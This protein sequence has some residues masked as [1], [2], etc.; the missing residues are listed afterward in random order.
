MGEVTSIT[1]QTFRHTYFTQPL[2]IGRL[3]SNHELSFEQ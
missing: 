2:Q 3:T 1:Y